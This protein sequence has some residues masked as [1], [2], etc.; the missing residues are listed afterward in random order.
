MI[1][2]NVHGLVH[3]N[4]WVP[5]GLFS[6]K[7]QELQIYKQQPSLIS[8]FLSSGIIKFFYQPLRW[9]AKWPI[10]YSFALLSH[11]LF[12]LN[13]KLHNLLAYSWGHFVNRKGIT[14]THHITTYHIS[15]INTLLN[16]STHSYQLNTW[17]TLNPSLP[18]SNIE[19]TLCRRFPKK[20]CLFSFT[21]NHYPVSDNFKN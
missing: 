19:V 15:I 5:F 4:Q 3:A 1:Q 21:F 10:Q 16:T 7:Y 14:S 6:P 8:L 12:I 17:T 18:N 9:T 20:T 13:I 2:Q 11:S